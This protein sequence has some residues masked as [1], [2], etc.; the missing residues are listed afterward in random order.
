MHVPAWVQAVYGNWQSASILQLML[1]GDE[2]PLPL[3]GIG[4]DVVV[5]PIHAP[6]EQPLGHCCTI[7]SEQSA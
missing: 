2:S 7:E 1:W 5:P 4:L 3:E 6:L